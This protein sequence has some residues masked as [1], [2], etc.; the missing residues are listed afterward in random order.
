MRSWLTQKIFTRLALIYGLVTMPPMPPAPEDSAER[1]LSI[2]RLLK[3]LRENQDA[4]VC[5]APEGM[6]FPGGTLGVPHPG[7]GKLLL[8]TA[9]ITHKVLPAGVYEYDGKLIIHFGQPYEL[10]ISELREDVDRAAADLVMQKIA[11]LLPREMRGP[12]QRTEAEVFE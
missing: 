9:G 5:I 3:K 1:A 12:Y 8:Q 4:I 11:E 2:R 10:R 6:D 7:T